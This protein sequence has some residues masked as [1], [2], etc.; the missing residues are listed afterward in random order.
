MVANFEPWVLE[1]MELLQ[2]IIWV[3]KCVKIPFYYYGKF[4]AQF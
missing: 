2:G 1:S 4:I 3:F